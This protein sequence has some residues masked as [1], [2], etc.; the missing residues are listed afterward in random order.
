MHDASYLAL[1]RQASIQIMSTVAQPLDKLLQSRIS[2]EA[3]KRVR[4]QA[5]LRG[6]TPGAIVNDLIVEKLP[7][8]DPALEV[9]LSEDTQ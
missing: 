2:L 5:A 9:D 6:C 3:W 8:V 7:A 4:V 1:L